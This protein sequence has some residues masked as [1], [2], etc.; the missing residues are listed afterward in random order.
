MTHDRSQ[1]DAIA[2]HVYT[3][4]VVREVAIGAGRPSVP[5]P[6]APQLP[7]GHRADERGGDA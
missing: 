3:T 2:N 7:A 5:F 1:I 6:R 4:P